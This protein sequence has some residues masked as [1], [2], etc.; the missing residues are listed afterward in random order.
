MLLWQATRQVTLMTG[1]AAP[2][3]AMRAALEG[4]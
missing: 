3:D 4:T 1:L 2:V